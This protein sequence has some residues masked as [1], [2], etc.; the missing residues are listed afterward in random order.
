M[1]LAD[2]LRKSE[3]L[4][5]VDE[6]GQEEIL[7]LSSP[8]SDSELQRLRDRLPC[9]LPGEVER[10]LRVSR[11]FENGPLD[12]FDFSGLFEESIL[13]E[14]FPHAVTLGG[15]G[16]GNYWVVDLTPDST[17]FG[18]VFYLCHDP[19]VVVYQAD[20][21]RE[22]VEELLALAN[23]PHRSAIDAVHEE[24]SFRIW[25]ETPGTIPA[26]ECRDSADDELRAFTVGLDDRYVI[27][28]LRTARIGDGFAWGR[29]SDFEHLRRHGATRLFAYP[30]RRTLFRRLFSRR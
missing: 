8:L 19:P 29:S 22:F 25:S 16:F 11:G 23:P 17:S 14:L 5:M 7:R 28:D 10:A 6:D 1:E 30:P 3:G 24:H 15:D 18:P 12:W 2:L 27:I 13:P 4:R 21:I 20:Q 9:A 26:S